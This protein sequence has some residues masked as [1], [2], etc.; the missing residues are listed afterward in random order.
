MCIVY[1]ICDNIEYIKYVLIHDILIYKYVL[2][3]YVI[4]IDYIIIL[5]RL[6]NREILIYRLLIN[7]S[8][9]Q[10]RHVR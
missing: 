8:G 7:I 6:Y 9:A 4:Y 5:H 10:R 3:V 2:Y 1:H